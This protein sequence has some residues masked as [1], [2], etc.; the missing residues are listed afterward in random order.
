MSSLSDNA[1]LRDP[2]FLHR[3][4]IVSLTEG[5]STLILFFIAMPLKY[6]LDLPAA[7]SWAGRIHG[8][9]FMLLV[10][11][12]VIAVKKVPI[13]EKLALI[14]VVAAIFPF[15]PFLVDKK[16]RPAAYQ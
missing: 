5:C 13:P 12:A 7:V 2:T 15:G 9:L 1:A 10:V 8:G 4:R 14:L 6:G 3:L 16:L 11:M